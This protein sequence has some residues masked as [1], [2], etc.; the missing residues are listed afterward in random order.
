[1]LVHVVTMLMVAV[2]VVNVVSVPVVFD[3]FVAVTLGVDTVVAF[4]NH[5]FSVVLAIMNMVNVVIVFNGFVSVTWEVLVVLGR[6]PISHCISP[7]IVRTSV[8]CPVIRPY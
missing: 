4:V 8:S 1:M 6:M 3:G 5:F 7:I 2:P